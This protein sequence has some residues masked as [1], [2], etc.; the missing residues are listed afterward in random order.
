MSPLLVSHGASHLLTVVDHSTRRP[1]AILLSLITAGKCTCN[2]CLCWVAQLGVPLHF[3]LNHGSQF[4]SSLWTQLWRTPGMIHWTASL[5]YG[6]PS[7]SQWTG[8]AV[9]QDLQ[10][11]ALSTPFWQQLLWWPCLSLTFPVLYATRRLW[12]VTCFAD[13][14]ALFTSVWDDD[15]TYSSC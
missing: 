8:L 15:V 1:E 2:F 13:V 14:I 3:T 5:K 9:P 4:V 12:F 10:I 6:L 7:A 11:C